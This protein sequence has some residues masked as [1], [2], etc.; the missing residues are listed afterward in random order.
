M[1]LRMAAPSNKRLKKWEFPEKSGIWIREFIYS[2]DYNGEERIYSAYQVTVPG[3]VQGKDCRKRK[4]KQ[5]PT[6]E[7]A[8]AWAREQAAGKGLL[9]KSFFDFS[10]DE[11]QEFVTCMSKLQKKKLTLTEAVDF[12]LKH[13]RPT[14]GDKTV[15]EITEE[16]I[17]S[18]R[19]RFERGNLRPRS[20]RDFSNRSSKFAK[21]FK[22][23]PVY[24][25]T[26]GDLKGWLSGLGVAPRTTANYL[27]VASEVLKYAVQK[28]YMSLSPVD[29]LTNQEREELCGSNGQEG[30]PSILT[31]EEATRLLEAAREHSELDLLGAVILGNFCGIRVEELKR[32][33]WSSVRDKEDSPIVTISGAIAKKRRIR[34]VDI[35]ANALQWLSLC[36][37]REGTVGI[38]SPPSEH[39]IRFRKLT[40]LAGFGHVDKNGNWKSEWKT[41]SCRHSFASFHYALHGNPLE[42]ARQLG[43]KASDQTLFDHYRA[44]VRPG[45]AEKYFGITPASAANK[46]VEFAG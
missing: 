41:N 40:K 2:Q 9:G 19:T 12:A 29:Q 8:E 45:Q 46:V 22:D 37:D 28:G 7:D 17:G 6:K 21:A 30:E 16:L 1:L 15:G 10:N 33:S 3:K 42:T 20:F 34:H 44:L 35:P 25:L 27:I 4:R 38:S 14:G 11:R 26:V 24:D 18:K 31:I 39:D 32:L 23:L 43:H 5:C 36:T 13:L